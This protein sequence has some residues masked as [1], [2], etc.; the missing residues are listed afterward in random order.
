IPCEEVQH[1]P[2]FSWL[3]RG[4]P[5]R[6]VT[7]P[8]PGRTSAE[9][10]QLDGAP[11]RFDP[12]RKRASSSTWNGIP[13]EFLLDALAPLP[14]SSCAKTKNTI[15]D[16]ASRCR[17]LIDVADVSDCTAAVSPGSNTGSNT[18]ST[19]TFSPPSTLSPS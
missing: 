18:N 14:P 8:F 2:V 11:D 9:A 15:F 1:L 7:P 12:P 5:A 4:V 13:P 19:A 10:L 6:T 3:S 16:D 17:A